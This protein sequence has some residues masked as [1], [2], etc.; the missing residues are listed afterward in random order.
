[1]QPGRPI[2]HGLGRKSTLLVCI[3]TAT[4]RY[5]FLC[6]QI[7]ALISTLVALTSTMEVVFFQSDMPVHALVNVLTTPDGKIDFLTLGRAFELDPGAITLYDS[8]VPQKDGE[9]KATWTQ[10]KQILNVS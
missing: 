4:L 10:L 1:M 5:F 6:H 2:G 7:S 8:L 9:S 3:Y